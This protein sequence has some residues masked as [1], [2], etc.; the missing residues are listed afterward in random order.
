L[1]GGPLK[2]RIDVK[3]AAHN[4]ASDGNRNIGEPTSALGA[5]ARQ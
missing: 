5:S 4:G 2:R 3:A 1:S